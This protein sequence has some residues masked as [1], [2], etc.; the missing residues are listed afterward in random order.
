MISISN[1]LFNFERLRAK[2]I[3]FLN[4]FM[5]YSI[6]NNLKSYKRADKPKRLYKK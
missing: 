5:S 4:R 1:G 6:T 3:Y 2:S